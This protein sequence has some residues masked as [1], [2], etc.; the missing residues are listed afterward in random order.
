[1]VNPFIVPLIKT[2]LKPQTGFTKRTE[3][4]MEHREK[5][6]LSGY[7][8]PALD[9][10]RPPLAQRL[11]D[12]VDNS[13]LVVWSD[14]A[15]AG[16]ILVSRSWKYNA[17]HAAKDNATAMADALAGRVLLWQFVEFDATRHAVS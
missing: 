2:E 7:E 15:E 8:Y 4:K 12:G 11:F 13:A 3:R 9:Y 16:E 10:G 17:G 6:T 5:V 14:N 1:L